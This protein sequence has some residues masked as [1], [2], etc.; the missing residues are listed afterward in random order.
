VNETPDDLERLQHLLETSYAE[1][2]GHLTA[3]HT[4]A[5]RITAADLA[6][7]LQGMQV[8][9]VATV[10]AD[11]RPFT[12][13][14]DA[15]LHR[16]RVVFGTAREAVRARHLRDRP[17][18]SVTHVRGEELVV[19]VHGRAVPIDPAADP[20][21]VATMRA[22]YGPDWHPAAEGAVYFVV[23]PDRMFAADMTVHTAAAVEPAPA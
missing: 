5:A 18:V 11:G 1:A 20:D 21:L 16:G 6:D 7:R 8:V 4:P 15:F 13:P 2:G 22:W 9:V 23:D 10:S 17:V 14:V 12:G 19:T 3:I